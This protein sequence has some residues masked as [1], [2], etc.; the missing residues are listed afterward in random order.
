MTRVKTFINNSFI[1]G[2][3]ILLPLAILAVVF[4]WM[5]TTITD[6]IQPFTDL[7]IS[8]FSLPEVIGDAL[9]IIFMALLCFVVGSL[10]STSLGRYIHQYFDRYFSRMAPGYRIIKDI[11]NQFFGDNDDSPFMNGVVARVQLFGQ[12]VATTATALVTSV[13]PDGS[14]TVFVPTGPNPTSGMIYHLPKEC[15]ELFPEI[16]VDA[17]LKTVISCGAGSSD[18]FKEKSKSVN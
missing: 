3:L 6:L 11:V 1:G 13:H 5:F 7:V 16:N 4:H 18:L 2:I 15:V 8:S 12:D 14:Y 10:V 9:V 17:M